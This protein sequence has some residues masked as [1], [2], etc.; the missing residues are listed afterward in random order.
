MTD[1]AAWDRAKTA[2][3][4]GGYDEDTY[5]AV[6][7]HIYERMGG[8]QNE[9]ATNRETPDM[10]TREQNI[11][12]LTANCDC[13]KG[14]E[15]VLSNKDAFSDDDLAKLVK[16]AQEHKDSALVVN[17][18]REQLK[19]DPKLAVNA[20]P[21][22]LKERMKSAEEDEGEEEE[23]EEEE[24][25]SKAKP[26][27]N[28]RAWKGLDDWLK[29]P[30]SAPQEVK[31]LVKNG[32]KVDRREKRKLVQQLLGNV[33]DDNKR[34]LLANRYM[35]KPLDE[36][37]EL[38]SLIP[39]R[40]DNRREEDDDFVPSYVGA[41]GGPV[42]NSDDDEVEAADWDLPVNNFAGGASPRLLERLA[43]QRSAVPTQQL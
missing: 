20:M 28:A 13:W 4:K 18:V 15:K 34:K 32:I 43:K 21:A 16:N 35:A 8:T 9:I 27:Q 39:Q 37:E 22:F 24:A 31:E 33:R 36:L 2:A 12:T 3:D 42:F 5:W 19:I 7:A 1:E 11:K 30:A 6:V 25:N 23:E 10:A 41:G 38:V 40:A 17:A 14:K 29:D 26:A